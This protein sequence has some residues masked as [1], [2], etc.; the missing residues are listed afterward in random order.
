VC[1]G[2]EQETRRT[3]SRA[4][5]KHQTSVISQTPSK[6][7][8]FAGSTA[9]FGRMHGCRVVART[10]VIVLGSSWNRVRVVVGGNDDRE[11]HV[12]LTS[13][14]RRIYQISF[15]VADMGYEK[16]IPP[17]SPSHGHVEY[18]AWPDFNHQR[19]QMTR[20]PRHAHSHRFIQ[21][22]LSRWTASPKNVPWVFS[23][24]H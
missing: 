17:L 12:Y 1:A 23:P 21:S 3:L 11:V 19:I 4:D 14:L 6:Q 15:S 20:L 5:S 2:D 18:V 24:H 16:K 7:R 9:R 13:L 10:V 8:L 22:Q